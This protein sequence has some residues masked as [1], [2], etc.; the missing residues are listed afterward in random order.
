MIGLLAGR[1]DRENRILYVQAP[2]SCA[3]TQR[4]D[5]DDGSVDVE[6]DPV[7]EYEVR[8]VINSLGLRVVGW[9]HSHPK[10]KPNP[11]VTDIFNQN[12]YQ[13]LMHDNETDLDPFVGL[14][15][16]TFDAKLPS[17]ES[18][19][20]WFH[21]SKVDDPKIL[22]SSK[23]SINIPMKLNVSVLKFKSDSFSGMGVSDEMYFVTVSI[24][25]RPSIYFSILQATAIM[26]L[27]RR[28]RNL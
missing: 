5:D 16:S 22:T 3:A 21:V 25:A 2:F 23:R 13:Q 20:Q 4:T 7:A 28:L 12:Q 17:F 18:R 27:L 1:W 19:H 9:Y 15:I 14:I 10:F 11:S 6:L 8:E 24:I 26:S